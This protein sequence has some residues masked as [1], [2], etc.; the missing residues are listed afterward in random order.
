MAGI[1]TNKN[2]VNPDTVEKLYRYT[3]STST[4]SR[5][6]LCYL[7]STGTHKAALNFHFVLLAFY[8]THEAA[9]N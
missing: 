4:F 3:Q 9:L 5:F 1:M 8:R 6:I 7:R 2:F